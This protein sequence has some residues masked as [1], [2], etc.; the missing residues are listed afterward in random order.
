MLSQVSQGCVG[1]P[2]LEGRVERK[3][4]T[5]VG[6]LKVECIFQEMTVRLWRPEAEHCSLDMKMYPMGSHV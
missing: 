4:K 6:I 1:N 3:T 5:T 2:V